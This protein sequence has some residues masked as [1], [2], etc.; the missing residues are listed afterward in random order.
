MLV[1]LYGQVRPGPSSQ[2]TNNIEEVVLPNSLNLGF[3]DANTLIIETSKKSKWDETAERV[4]Q[5]HTELWET[6]SEL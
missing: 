4:L 2:T 6:L 1:E 3:Y 5:E